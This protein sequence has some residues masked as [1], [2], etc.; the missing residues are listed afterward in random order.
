MGG[1]GGGGGGG[2]VESRVRAS[3]VVSLAMFPWPRACLRFVPASGREF[4][5][6]RRAGSGRDRPVP[7]RPPRQQALT[8]LPSEPPSC[9]SETN[10]CL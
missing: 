8:W 7:Q 3:A 6:A 2:V 9:G 4:A 1:G 5:R 10:A